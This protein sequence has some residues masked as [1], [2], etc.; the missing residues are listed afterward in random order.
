MSQIVVSIMGLLIMCLAAYIAAWFKDGK[1]RAG[2]RAS[3]PATV[4]L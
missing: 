4:P 1:P 2:G 3:P